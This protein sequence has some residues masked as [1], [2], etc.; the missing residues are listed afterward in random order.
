[1]WTFDLDEIAWT[2]TVPGA[3]TEETKARFWEQAVPVLAA[4]DLP[5]PGPRCCVVARVTAPASAGRGLPAGPR[6]RAKGILDALHDD[7]SRGPLYRELGVRS[8]LIDDDPAAV[9]GLAVEVRTGATP[10]VEYRVGQGLRVN[11]PLL[12]TLDVDAAGP[13]DIAGTP[14]DR[15][16]IAAGR[17]RLAA[18][19]RAA[20]LSKATPEDLPAPA[21]VVVDHHP[22]RDEDNTWATWMAALCPSAGATAAHWSYGGPLPGTNLSALASLAEP[23]LPTPTR[24]RL[25]T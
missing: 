7:R 20:W 16:T 5:R 18:A 23:S 10:A 17:A 19:T 1:M 8:P 3:P 12:L 25:Y 21:A 4:A 15:V 24:Y 13:N 2:L 11:R 14:S 9:G 22:A 6:A